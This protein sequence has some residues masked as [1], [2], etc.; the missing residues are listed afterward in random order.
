MAKTTPQLPSGSLP[1]MPVSKRPTLPREPGTHGPLLKATHGSPERPLRIGDIAIPCYVLENG[2]RVIAENG[3][4]VAM[5]MGRGGAG[6]RLGN[7]AM[8]KSIN[9]Y[10]T[11][12]LA[13]AISQ[14][15]RF[16]PPQGG[17]RAYGYEATV[18]A[19]ICQAVLAA[20]K[21]GVLR[22]SQQ[23]IADRCEILLQ[24]FSRVGIIA[25]V[26]EATGYQHDRDREALHKIL[27]AY[28]SPDLLPWAKQFPDTFYE[29]LC[30]LRGWR[31][32]PSYKGPRYIAQLT[33]HLVYEKLPP[34]VLDEL[35]RLNPPV[36][37]GYR[38]K[39][40]LHQFLTDNIG[41]PHLEKHL[42]QVLVL[43]RVSESWEQF[44]TLFHRVFPPTEMPALGASEV[45]AGLEVT[46]VQ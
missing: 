1:Q 21:A 43:L 12:A 42:L 41:H 23:H 39:Y 19:D 44:E 22:P 45:D 35:R 34:G 20:R 40:R 11:P 36:R 46:P 15:I 13:R 8:G 37:Q 38:R 6:Y 5:D 27:A 25:L 3:L 10:I 31:Y 4:I 16:Q 26:D 2:Q 29:Q 32:H 30:R 24:G 33:N 7:F 18:L 14:P 28:I 9:P 17:H